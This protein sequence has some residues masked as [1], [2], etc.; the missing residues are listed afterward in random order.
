MQ[1]YTHTDGRAL[2]ASGSPFPDFHGFGKVFRFCFEHWFIIILVADVQ[3]RPGQQCLHFPWCQPC[4]HCR[5][6]KYLTFTCS[7]RK[8][9]H[10]M[11]PD[12]LSC[13]LHLWISHLLS[14]I[15]LISLSLSSFEFTTCNS[16][17]P[18]IQAFTT[19]QTVCSFL[20]QK[21]LQIWSL[22]KISQSAGL[23]LQTK[24]KSSRDWR[25]LKKNFIPSGSTLLS[26]TSRKFLCK[27]QRGCVNIVFP[28]RTHIRHKFS[29]C[30]GSIWTEYGINLSRARGQG[31]FH[32]DSPLRLQLW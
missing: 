30:W 22:K 17:F 12:L 24:H 9:L 8:G 16:T 6:W 4:R 5:R 15:I 14:I 29:G 7:D 2:F 20:R 10:V 23:N 21:L 19:S 25:K 28:K 3:A 13:I 27:L 32:S 11:M 18:F 31:G 1:A 26:Q